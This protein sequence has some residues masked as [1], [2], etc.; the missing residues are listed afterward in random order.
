MKQKTP[1]IH[2]KIVVTSTYCMVD[3]SI[4]YEKLDFV[5]KHIKLCKKVYVDIQK[6]FSIWWKHPEAQKLEI[7]IRVKFGYSPKTYCFDILHQFSFIYRD[8]INQKP[9]KNV[10]KSNI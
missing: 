9:K 6:N 10:K 8:Y 7:L 4:K 3:A 5:K 1:L 2:R